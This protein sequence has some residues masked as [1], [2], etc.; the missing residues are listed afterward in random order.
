MSIAK[1]PPVAEGLAQPILKPPSGGDRSRMAAQFHN[2]ATRARAVIFVERLWPRLVPPLCMGGLGLSAAWLQLWQTLPPGGRIVALLAFAAATLASPALMKTKSLRVTREE[3]LQRLDDNTG[4]PRRPARTLA[5]KPA[6]GSIE[7]ADEIRKLHVAP[8]W[9]TWGGKFQAG[10]PRS[11][12]PA[13]DPYR[14]RYVAAA[15]TV[16][17]G[18]LAG[19]DA[20]RR[21]T[22]VFDFSVPVPPIPLVEAEADIRG[23]DKIANAPEFRLTAQSRETRQAHKNSIM[24]LRVFGDN[25]V[26]VNGNDL[27]PQKIM[28]AGAGTQARPAY[29]YEFLLTDEKTNITI[30]NGPQWRIAVSPDTPPTIAMEE[31]GRDPANPKTLAAGITQKD[32]HGIVESGIHMEPQVLQA[33]DATPLPSAQLPRLSLP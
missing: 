28:R 21:L 9:D 15:C 5:D 23:P 18:V 1:E 27:T 16:L 26:S 3:A 25:K 7:G 17:T 6:S 2:A 32:D 29:R 8:I 13:R 30:V 4:D 31:V 19:Q 10:R 11:D 24:T 14:L 33:V 22:S 20:G 12:V